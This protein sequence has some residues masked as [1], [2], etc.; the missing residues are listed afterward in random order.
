MDEESPKNEFPELEP[1]DFYLDEHGLIVFTATY[2]LKRGSC[3]GN[4]CRNCPYPGGEAS[5]RD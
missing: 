3:C 1:E 5:N 4:G 2:L